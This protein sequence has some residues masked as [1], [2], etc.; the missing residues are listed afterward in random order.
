MYGFEVV[1]FKGYSDK[2]QNL[3]TVRPYD[4]NKCVLEKTGRMKHHQC[5][6]KKRKNVT[7]IPASALPVLVQCVSSQPQTAFSIARGTTF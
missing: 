1:R 6:R 2:P 3:T 7:K 4:R 5:M